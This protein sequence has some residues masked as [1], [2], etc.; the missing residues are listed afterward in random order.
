MTPRTLGRGARRRP[1]LPLLLVL[2]VACGTNAGS[3]PG[4]RIAE[5]DARATIAGGLEQQVTLEPA[6]LVDGRDVVVRSVLRNRGQA[7]L[8]LEHRECGLDYAGT[9]TLT[10]PPE[11]LK[12]A[13]YSISRTLAPGDSAVTSDLMRVASAPGRYTLRVRHALAPSYWLELDV[14][15]REP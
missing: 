10:H 4:D 15:V 3:A 11:V 2:A 6:T 8:A 5:G 13:G 1:L 12:C 14:V 7:P 9:L